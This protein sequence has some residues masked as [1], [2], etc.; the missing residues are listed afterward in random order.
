MA[1]KFFCLQ[2][3]LKAKILDGMHDQSIPGFLRDAISCP[4]HVVT[5]TLISI[6]RQIIF[7]REGA[8][9]SSSLL[10]IICRQI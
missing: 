7:K 9:L 6:W 10:N 3:C 2:T 8:R 1:V 5:F 4:I